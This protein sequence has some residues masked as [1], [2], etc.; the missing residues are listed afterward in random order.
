MYE[1]T[2]LRT[3]IS[4]RDDFCNSIAFTV[5]NKSGKGGVDGILAVFGPPYFVACQR[6]LWNGSV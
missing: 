2:V 6:V 1:E 5:I 4:L 3:C